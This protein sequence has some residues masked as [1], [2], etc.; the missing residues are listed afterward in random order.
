MGRMYRR[1][2]ALGEDLSGIF[3]QASA[4]VAEVLISN[5]RHSLVWRSECKGL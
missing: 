2:R 1:T 4:S 5:S 3:Y